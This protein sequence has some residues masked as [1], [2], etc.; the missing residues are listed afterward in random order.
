MKVRVITSIVFAAV[1]LPILFLSKHI[2]YP[3]ALSL[4]GL[5]AVFEMLRVLGTQKNYFVSVPAYIA[6]LA[7]PTCAYF[8]PFEKVRTFLLI[9]AGVLFAY[10][11][12]LFFLAVFMRG[13]LEFCKVAEVFSTVTYIVSSFTA[14]SVLRYMPNGIW[15]LSLVFIGAWGSDVSAYF[16]GSFLGKHKLIPE[17]SPKKTIEGSVGA[18]VIA[19]GLF[20]LFGFILDKATGVIPNYLVLAVSGLLLSV[21]SQLGDLIASLIKRE[22][23]VKDYGKILPGHGGVMDRFDSVLAV[24]TVLMIICIIF[25]PFK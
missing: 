22:H 9:L 8:V 12:Y 5:V 4:F 7:L 18:I 20:V 21:V 19:T 1:G 10:L 17:I 6:I 14:L 25:P 11:I 13:S 23:G 16:V 3:I 2:I 15:N 24:T